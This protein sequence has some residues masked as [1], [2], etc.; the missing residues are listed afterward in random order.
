MTDQKDL[1]PEG[2]I[3]L[4]MPEVSLH[5]KVYRLKTV[6]RMWKTGMRRLRFDFF[7]CRLVRVLQCIPK[8]LKKWF[9][10]KRAVIEFVKETSHVH[11]VSKK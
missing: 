9:R 3:S 5:R 10:M 7:R 6:C 2:L 1:K 4:L 8:F 11:R